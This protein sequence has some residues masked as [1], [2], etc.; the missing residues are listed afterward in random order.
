MYS[1]EPIN[2]SQPSPDQAL[3]LLPANSTF[4]NLPSSLTEL[5]NHFNKPNN[6]SQQYTMELESYMSQLLRNVGKLG[7]FCTEAFGDVHERISSLQ[8]T[9][10]E[11]LNRVVL[12]SDNLAIAFKDHIDH[13]HLL[14]TTTNKSIERIS[15]EN[16][17][18]NDGFRMLYNCLI[19]LYNNNSELKENFVR[20][21]NSNSAANLNSN[22]LKLQSD[23]LQTFGSKLTDL[24]SLSGQLSKKIDHLIASE[25]ERRRLEERVKILEKDMQCL[26]I[27]TSLIKDQD[28]KNLQDKT[29]SLADDISEIRGTTLVCEER[30]SRNLAL[31]PPVLSYQEKSSSEKKKL[32]E[33]D[34]RLD[35]TRNKLVSLDKDIAKLRD[36]QPKTKDIEHLCSAILNKTLSSFKYEIFEQVDNTLS[37]LNDSSQSSIPCFDPNKELDKIKEAVQSV[38]SSTDSF[39]ELKNWKVDSSEI[40]DKLEEKIKK[41]QLDVSDIT[42]PNKRNEL[43]D[44]LKVFHDSL[45]QTTSALNKR[46]DEINIHFSKID[47]S[48]LSLNDHNDQKKLLKHLNDKLDH[49]LQI[50][51][52]SVDSKLQHIK[53]SQ[54]IDDSAPTHSWDGKTLIYQT[55]DGTILD[56]S[57]VQ[58][59]CNGKVYLKHPHQSKYQN[60]PSSSTNLKSVSSDPSHKHHLPQPYSSSSSSHNPSNTP[61]HTQNKSHRSF[62]PICRY[63]IKCQNSQCSLRHPIYP[64][65]NTKPRHTNSRYKVKNPSENTFNLQQ[66]LLYLNTLSNLFGHSK[67]SK[68]TK[69]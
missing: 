9:A 4:T 24:D 42:S 1:A 66:M 14:T 6:S 55:Q 50:F 62:R 16:Q 49:E 60:P 45:S 59:S 32:N 5:T 63:G 3:A 44:H 41:L 57:E 39:Q 2:N 67:P 25:P 17:T 33:I 18:L 22:L 61:H 52:K 21:Q 34:K 19:E 47:K 30:L 15:S 20:M 23:Q 36:N 54:N 40:T 12:K 43:Q 7:E 27:S 31:I 29:S 35:E 68:R 64:T 48:I 28:I 26:K 53:L 56:P 69:F 8:I 38:I 65:P 51:A 58:I 13:S 46:L 10:D 11:A 37:H